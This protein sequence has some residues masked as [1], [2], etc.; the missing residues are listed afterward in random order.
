MEADLQPRGALPARPCVY[1]RAR[2]PARSVNAPAAEWRDVA[3]RCILV[4]RFGLQGFDCLAHR[5]R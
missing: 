5:L 4:A 2:P 3:L 1:A